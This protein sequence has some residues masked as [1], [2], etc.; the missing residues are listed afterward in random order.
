[1]IQKMEKKYLSEAL[2]IFDTNHN[3]IIELSE[4]Y[5]YFENNNSD[6]I[7]EKAIELLKNILL[8]IFPN[9]NLQRLPL[10]IDA[11]ITNHSDKN[12][13][14]DTTLNLLKLYDYVVRFIAP[15]KYRHYQDKLKD[16]TTFFFYDG[17]IEIEKLEIF[18][19]ERE[20]LT[21]ADIYYI[22]VSYHIPP[23]SVENIINSIRG[24]DT[25]YEAE[26]DS[27]DMQAVFKLLS[28]KRYDKYV[29]DIDSILDYC[30]R[31]NIHIKI[32]N[33]FH[34]FGIQNQLF[35]IIKSNKEV[36]KEAIHYFLG[37]KHEHY[38]NLGLKMLFDALEIKVNELT[39]V[40]HLFD[41]LGY[42]GNPHKIFRE[43][44]SLSDKFTSDDMIV[45]L[46]DNRIDITL[47][48]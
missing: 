35:Q 29:I 7:K 11:L 37:F 17:I 9:E 5:A 41:F 12:E 28:D 32:E 8:T 3:Q 26:D 33:I 27:L 34:L 2:E 18:T 38:F 40:I 48:K 23:H 44:S 24:A 16:K 25:Y 39:S 30:K 1:M 21:C 15:Q 13:N 10:L 43:L 6:E 47:E 4:W 20:R 36:Q 14:G 19:D 46:K 31:Q 42:K 22:L 45:F